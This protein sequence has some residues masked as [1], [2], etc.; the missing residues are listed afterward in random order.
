M[1]RDTVLRAVGV[2]HKRG[3]IT[4][5]QKR[6]SDH[7]SIGDEPSTVADSCSSIDYNQKVK[8]RSR[9]LIV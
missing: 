6:L 5:F 9:V 4:S 7:L 8:M 3:H 2:L 1:R